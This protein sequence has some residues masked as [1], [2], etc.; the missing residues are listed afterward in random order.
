MSILVR[1]RL[2]VA[3]AAAVLPAL[4][5]PAT[6][7]QATTER[8]AWSDVR[9]IDGR[10]LPASQLNGRTVVV[11]MYASWCPFCAK[12]S[13]L[14]QQ[15]HLAQSRSPSGLLV[16]GFSIDRTE[17]A[18]L[19][20]AARHGYTW[21]A[22]MATPQVEAWFGKRRALPEVYVVDRGRVVHRDSGEMFAEDVAALARFAER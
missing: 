20:Y 2:V 17:K 11:Y 18:A 19:D 6:L 16:L 7:A 10:V 14:M 3:G 8:V 22:A 1:R 13:P 21:A 4:L 9:L 5:P 15:L 12:Q